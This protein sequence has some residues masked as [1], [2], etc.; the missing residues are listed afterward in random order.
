VLGRRIGSLPALLVLTFRGGEAPPG[1]PLRAAIGGIRADHS[2][3]LELASLSKRAVASLA[4]DRADEVYGATAGNPFYVAE[5]LA[6]RTASD[7]PPSIANAVLGRASR[8]D[9]ASRRLVELVSVVPS[10]VATSLLDAVM[11]GWPAAAE[12]PE[13]RQ[14][15]EVDASYVHFRHELARNAIRSSVPIARRRG[16]HAE[17][18]EALLAANADPADIVHHGEAAGAEDVVAEYA[19][20]AAR[21][22]AALESNREAHSHYRRAADFVDRLSPPEQATV[23]EELAD[24]AY[25]A[26]RL[27]DAF[28]AIERAIEI[29]AQLGDDGA[30]GRC[31]RVKS[32]LHW[33]AGRNDEFDRG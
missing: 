3:V 6:S 29:H 28:P 12:E 11:P 30:V 17:I 15:L 7:I 23:L 25:V 26:V 19:V 4:G 21:R 14:L 20:V 8:L 13:R 2:V 5:L 18:L 16:L 22:A 33:F 24:A 27:E 1:H 9:D 32:R 10:R 31:T